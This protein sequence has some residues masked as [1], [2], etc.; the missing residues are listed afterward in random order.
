MSTLSQFFNASNSPFISAGDGSDRGITITKQHVAAVALQSNNYPLSSGRHIELP[1]GRT[2]NLEIVGDDDVT[3]YSVAPTSFF[4]SGHEWAAV[5]IDN[6]NDRFMALGQHGTTTTNIFYKELDLSTDT[7]VAGTS[8]TT[9]TYGAD[10]D[11]A[12]SSAYGAICSRYD[13]THIWFYFKTTVGLGELQ[14][15]RSDGSVVSQTNN[16]TQAGRSFGG[17]FYPTYVSADGSIFARFEATL[18]TLTSYE[19]YQLVLTV[20]INGKYSFHVLPNDGN[21]PVMGW[22]SAQR[23]LNFNHDRGMVCGYSYN[24]Y[25]NSLYNSRWANV[26]EFD[27]WLTELHMQGVE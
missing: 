12:A 7:P 17:G 4:T 27:A 25:Q 5:A 11:V 21:Y 13:A 8:A 18:A 24:G 23:G 22:A 2:S 15:L 10:I 3:D 16:F 14:I 19:I 9:A 20:A 1:L 26:S 6:D